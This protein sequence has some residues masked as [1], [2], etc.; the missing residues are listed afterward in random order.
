MISLWVKSV[1]EKFMVEQSVGEQCVGGEKSVG[2]KY[3]SET[4]MGEKPEVAK[5]AGEKICGRKV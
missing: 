2:Q 5:S 1:G 3:M 4:G